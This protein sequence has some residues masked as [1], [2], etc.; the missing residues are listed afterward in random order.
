MRIYLLVS[1]LFLQSL[2]ACQQHPADSQ[3]TAVAN[4]GFQP[5]SAVGEVLENASSVAANIVF[6]SADGGQ[7]WQDFSAGLPP[8]LAVG[9]V[10][11][12]DNS[13]YLASENALYYRGTALV[14]PV[15]ANDFFLGEHISD[16]FPGKNGLYATAYGDG[17]FKGIPGTNFWNPMDHALR[18]K[19]IR[20][21]LET[22]DGT[23]FVGCESG[24]YKSADGG[25]SWDQMLAKE[26]VNIAAVTTETNSKD[27]VAI[28]TAVLEVFDLAQLSR[29]LHK[30]SRLPNIVEA[31]RPE[32]RVGQGG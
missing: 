25:K 30:I 18:D 31:Y 9:R 11:A 28:I 27:K 12:D 29:I 2:V 4:L 32:P 16:I 6:Q 24:L 1:L 23:V 20:C 5:F 15:W 26:G 14:A 7:T 8:K 19:T 13:I 3:A 21:V 17:F 22:P 10:Y